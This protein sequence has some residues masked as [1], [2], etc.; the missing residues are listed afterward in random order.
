MITGILILLP[1]I[2]SVFVM[3]SLKEG[4]IRR[5]ALFVATAEFIISVIA[6]LKHT[7][8]PDHRGDIF[9][10]NWI[11]NLDLKLS[12]GTD[13][14]SLLMVLLTTLLIV[15]IILASGSFRSRRANIFYGLILISESAL[16]GVF[17]ALNGL[18]FYIFWELALVPVYFIVAIWGGEGKIRIT[19]KFLIY[20]L[21]GSL[22]MLAA[23]IWVYFKTPEPHSFSF[24][25][26]YAAATTKGSQIWLFAAFFTAFAIKIPLVPFHTWQA[27]TYAVSPPAG[28][29]ILAGIM[30][31]M[32]IYGMIRFLIPMC[33]LALEDLR[34]WVLILITAGII[35][36]SIIALKQDDLKKFLAWV[37][38]AHV[39]LIS[40]AVLSVNRIALQGAVF[41]MLAHGVNIIALFIIVDL[42]EKRFNTRNISELGGIARKMPTLSVLFILTVLGTIALPLTNGFAGEFTMLLGLFSFNPYMAGVAGLTIIFGALYMLR[43]YQQVMLGNPVDEKIQPVQL[44][45]SDSVALVILV[46]IIIVTGIWPRP[47]MDLSSPAIDNILNSVSIL[48]N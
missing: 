10:I 27:D 4:A 48:T 31:K 28:S 46:L 17:T 43:M 39:G 25:A 24:S 23:L 41:Q 37:S 19:F 22:M 21:T 15:I 35:Y 11:S 6:L 42:L 44:S 12:F 30:L 16:I 2:G 38:I 5:N 36:S 33:P 1:L 20:T 45:T 3:F 9:S 29:M 8:G 13:G 34:I 40:A 14:L 7:S 26:L 32:G 18:V 47:L